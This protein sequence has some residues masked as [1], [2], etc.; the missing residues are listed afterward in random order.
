[1][2]CWLAVCELGSGLLARGLGL[3]RGL[4]PGLETGVTLRECGLAMA[5]LP[6]LDPGSSRTRALL[7]RELGSASGWS[8]AKGW[9]GPYTW[10]GGLSLSVGSSTLCSRRDEPR[11]VEEGMAQEGYC[12]CACV[13]IYICVCVRVLIGEVE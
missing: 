3:A 11:G 2:A 12:V 5:A 4:A 8:G 9:S 10:S 6:A 13:Y 1:M 7:T